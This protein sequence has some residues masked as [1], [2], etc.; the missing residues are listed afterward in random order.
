MLPANDVAADVDT[1]ESE[2]REQL[3]I[4]LQLLIRLFPEYELPMSDW[5]P[6]SPSAEPVVMGNQCKDIY[7]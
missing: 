3:S 1:D 2:A 6:E 4:R 5:I 7:E